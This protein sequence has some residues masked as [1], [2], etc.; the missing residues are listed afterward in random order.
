MAKICPVDGEKVIYLFCQECDDKVC[1]FPIQKDT[2]VDENPQQ[3]EE[4]RE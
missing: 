3:E 2:T 1:K 4:E